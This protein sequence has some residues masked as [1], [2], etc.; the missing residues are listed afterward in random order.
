MR[1]NNSGGINGG[2][3]N[4]MPVAFTVNMRPTPSISVKQ[5]TV[6]LSSM[7][8]EDLAIRGRH[9]ACIAV[10]AVPVIESA[11]AIALYDLMLRA[12]SL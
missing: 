10:R 9:D 8:Q 5:H 7:A 2:I 6:N 1:S 12:G 4:G 11:A 3:T